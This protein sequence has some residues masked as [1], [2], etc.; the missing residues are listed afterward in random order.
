V[1]NYD[2]LP[3]DL[4]FGNTACKLS[5]IGPEILHSKKGYLVG[6]CLCS[7]FSVESIARVGRV[8]QT[9]TGWLWSQRSGLNLASPVLR[10]VIFL[11]PTR[12]HRGLPMRA[13]WDNTSFAIL[14]NS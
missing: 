13:T 5:Q 9:M 7:N 10:L 14:T 1:F 8:C 11:Y 2:L 6:H 3:S 12:Q 4:V